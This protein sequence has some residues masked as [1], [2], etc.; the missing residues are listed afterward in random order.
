MSSVEWGELY[1]EFK[2]KK[3]NSKKLEAE[4]KE[5]MQ[6]EDV[7]KKSGIY[8]YVLTRNEKFLNIRA[9]TDKEKREAY[10]RQKG[11]CAK[12]KKPFAIEEME[13]DH[14][15]PWH[16]GGKTVAENCQML[17]KQ[18]NRTKAGK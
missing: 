17:C 15:K 10:E 1:N 7:T 11:K 9:F 5:L 6:D 4:I 18:D 16:E 14:I 3:L 12:C 2:D 13:A 8:P